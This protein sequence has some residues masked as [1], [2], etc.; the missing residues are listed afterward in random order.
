[1]ANAEGSKAQTSFRRSSEK[2]GRT[3]LFAWL[4]KAVEDSVALGR[5][6]R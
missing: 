3:V 4:S 6:R 1:M 2:P 5:S